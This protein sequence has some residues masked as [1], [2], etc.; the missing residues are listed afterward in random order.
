VERKGRKHLQGVLE[1]RLA[2]ERARAG[3]TQSELA[4]VSGIPLTTYRRLERGAMRNPPIRYLTNIALALD[5]HLFAICEDEWL[6]WTEFPSGLDEVPSKEHFV[7]AERWLES[8]PNALW[9]EPFREQRRFHTFV[10]DRKSLKA[11]KPRRPI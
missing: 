11:I 5:V 6:G 2:I 9:R 7:D 1:T 8:L 3:I 10:P 4:R